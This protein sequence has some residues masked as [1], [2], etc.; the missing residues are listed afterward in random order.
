MSADTLLSRLDRIKR[1]GPGRWIARCP[2]HDDKSPSLSVRELDDG[3]LL[4]HD[5]AG[6]DVADVLAAVGLDWDAIMPERAIDHHRPRER[7]PFN[8][9]D[10]LACLATESLIVAIV[11]ADI[12]NGKEVSSIDK[13]RVITAAARIEAARELAHGN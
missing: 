10:V 7:R 4:L 2:A 12:V 8:A 9:H 3:R 6:C 13:D 5:F 1:T 11:A